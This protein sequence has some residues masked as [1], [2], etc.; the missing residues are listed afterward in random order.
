[1]FPATDF[2]VDTRTVIHFRSRLAEDRALN[3]PGEA[4]QVCR[5]GVPFRC[6]GAA[7]EVTET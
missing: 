3:S 2:R 7:S 4:E 5:A 6:G 1:M